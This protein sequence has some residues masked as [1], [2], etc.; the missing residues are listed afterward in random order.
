LP[1][2]RATFKIPEAPK[3]IVGN[4]SPT[5]QLKKA[6]SPKLRSIVAEKPNQHKGTETVPKLQPLYDRKTIN[7]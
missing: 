4:I 5:V 3:E 2:S 7:A 6:V 1:L